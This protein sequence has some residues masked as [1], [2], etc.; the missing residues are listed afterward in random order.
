MSRRGEANSAPACN[1]PF[2][3]IACSREYI[4]REKIYAIA[5]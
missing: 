3:A 2:F 4:Y 5:I 1:K